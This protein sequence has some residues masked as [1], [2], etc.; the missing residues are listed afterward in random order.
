M[1]CGNWRFHY[2]TQM[3]RAGCISPTAG[4][5]SSAAKSSPFMGSS[6]F[7]TCSRLAPSL[8]Y[9]LVLSQISIALRQASVVR[10]TNTQVLKLRYFYSERLSP[11]YPTFYPI[12]EPSTARHAIMCVQ[13]V[14]VNSLWGFEGS[15]TDRRDS[16]SETNTSVQSAS[17]IVAMQRRWHVRNRTA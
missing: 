16:S 11:Q 3:V 8:F 6:M 12:W 1:L 2:H 13:V 15:V 5:D 17:C 10:Q 4:M 9:S 7:K 14:D